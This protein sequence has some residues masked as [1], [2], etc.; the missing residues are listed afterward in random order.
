MRGACATP[1]DS[2]SGGI[3]KLAIVALGQRMPDWADTACAD[4]AKRL[5]RDFA[6]EMIALKPAPRAKP[7]AQILALEAVRI[8]GA[9]GRATI[10]A[11]DEHGACW[12]SAEFA[13]RLG[14]WRDDATDIAFVIGSADGL[15]PCVKRGAAAT[16]C[17]SPMTLPHALARVVL[18]EQIYRAWSLLN[19]HPYHRA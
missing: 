3:L 2:R 11:L 19:G 14:R 7:V 13:Q 4:Y 17:L 1:P 12:S 15:D 10:V 6:I 18:H 8:L 9:C 16:L 5:P